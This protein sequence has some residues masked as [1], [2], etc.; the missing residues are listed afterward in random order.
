MKS[1]S[2]ARQEKEL[3]RLFLKNLPH[4]LPGDIFVNQSDA[5]ICL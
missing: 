3:P 5:T 1:G 4:I 2:Q